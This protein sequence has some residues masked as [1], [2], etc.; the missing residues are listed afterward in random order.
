MIT[1]SVLDTRDVA[2]G[3][4]TAYNGQGQPIDPSGDPV[5]LAFMPMPPGV[6]PGSG[7]WHTGSWAT[8]PAGTRFA[9][10]LV[11]PANGG[12]ALPVGDYRIWLKV[13]DNPEVP[14]AP[15]DILRIT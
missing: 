15:V 6:D 1:R 5:Q 2:I 7:D 8:S 13:T 12:V 9:Q 4:V 11:G 14:V 3:P 10:V